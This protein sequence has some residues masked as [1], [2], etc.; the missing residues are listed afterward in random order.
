MSHSY[1]AIATCG[2][3][4]ACCID[5]ASDPKW[6]ARRCFEFIRD[7]YTIERVTDREAVE[8]IKADLERHKL[9]VYTAKK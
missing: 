9:H 5:D 3:V 8:R 6:T 2:C 7:G 4:R 1:I